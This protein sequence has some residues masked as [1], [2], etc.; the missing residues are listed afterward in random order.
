M[1]ALPLETG[2]TDAVRLVAEAL[3]RTDV[4]PWAFDVEQIIESF[5]PGPAEGTHSFRFA[6]ASQLGLDARKMY[7][8]ADYPLSHPRH[9]TTRPDCFPDVA[10][11]TAHV[12]DV[13][14]LALRDGVL[15]HFAEMPIVI[16]DDVIVEDFS[17]RYAG[18]SKFYQFS[19][20]KLL[21]NTLDCD[22]T[23]FC[24]I[25]DISPPNFCHW[26]V[27][28]LPRLAAAGH[29]LNSP[30]FF[31]ATR[32]LNASYQIETLE[33]LGISRDRIIQLDHYQSV[34][35]RTLLVTSDTYRMPHPCFKCAP[36]A[37]DF[38]KARFLTAV[39]EEPVLKRVLSPSRKIYVSRKDAP[40]RMIINDDELFDQLRKR[41][42]RKVILSE[43][44]VSEQISVFQSATH[45]VSL[46]GA[47]F[48]HLAFSQKN[49]KVVEIFPGTYGTPAF[50]LLAA[51]QDMR[52][53][54]YVSNDVREGTRSQ[55][56]DI[57][58]DVPDFLDRCADFL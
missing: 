24:L 21:E 25:D 8:A 36:W 48:A 33:M 18:I 13:E 58:I 17:S 38:L 28:N 41:G 35:A 7:G 49:T 37:L 34:R 6:A 51:A 3:G 45:L 57:H 31:V 23:V 5:G 27:D 44:T 4:N 12:P 9:L 39:Q 50:Y 14:L 29:S 55:I 1:K 19:R 15:C 53:A 46:H 26:L 47:G 30:D 32:V 20:N 10:Q 54:T 2:K 52:Y 56:D 40:G 42:F 16:H 43:L 22:G 11:F